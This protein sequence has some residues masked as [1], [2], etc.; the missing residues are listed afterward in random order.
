MIK[1]TLLNKKKMQSFSHFDILHN[2]LSY[3]SIF[4]EFKKMLEQC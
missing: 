4:E 1:N 2:F 3:Q